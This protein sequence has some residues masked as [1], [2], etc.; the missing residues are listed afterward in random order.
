[1][2]DGNAV[3]EN[4]MQ[5]DNPS[6]PQSKRSKH[7]HTT[8]ESMNDHCL[9]HILQYLDSYDTVNMSLTCTR[10]RDF[11]TAFIYPKFARKIEIKMVDEAGSAWDVYLENIMDLKNPFLNF[12][13]FVEHLH[14]VGLYG[15]NES[16][17]EIDP[18]FFRCAEML[19]DLCPNLQSLSFEN[20]GF[21]SEDKHILKHVTSTLKELKFIGCSGI[22]YDWSGSLKRLVQLKRITFTGSKKTTNAQGHTFVKNLRMIFETCGHS[23]QELTL[24][25]I[26]KMKTISSMIANML[27]QLK[28]LE[29]EDHL[30]VILT[31][32]LIALPHLKFLH[33]DC[34]RRNVNSLLRILSDRGTIECLEIKNFTIGNVA[35]NEPALIFNKLR[36]FRCLQFWGSDMIAFLRLLTKSQMP[37]INY[38]HLTSIPDPTVVHDVLKFFES[39]KSLVSMVMNG[40]N[41]ENTFSLL[42]GIAEIL[43]TDGS[44]P[45][46]TIYNYG[47]K[48][49]EEEVRKIIM[50]LLLNQ[51]KINLNI[52][53]RHFLM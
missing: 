19:L 21:H 52:F 41:K 46:L 9:L 53:R 37:T 38:L 8:L 17:S 50:I 1:M 48:I 33:I 14:F 26:P 28:S 4:G 39:K 5:D 24:R 43:K 16:K 42:R 11:A 49:A 12:G 45:F 31:D 3:F 2:M 13:N 6:E 29:I 18:Q 10:L 36:R 44:R 35:D 47:L 15:L 22:T 40:S 34:L 20:V 7:S 51:L 32:T 27:P 25:R 30:S 23:I